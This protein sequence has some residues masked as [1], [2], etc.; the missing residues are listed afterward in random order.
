LRI[1]NDEAWYLKLTDVERGAKI[2]LYH[3]PDCT[4]KDDYR[5][6]TVQRDIMSY[7]VDS[8]ESWYDDNDVRVRWF[9]DNGLDGKVS[10]IEIKKNAY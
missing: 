4:T 8:F 5:E 1:D 9:Q 6:I 3:D 7:K 2:T 10:C